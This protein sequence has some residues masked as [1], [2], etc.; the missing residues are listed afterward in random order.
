MDLPSEQS[1][2]SEP[3]RIK[4]PNKNN[5]DAVRL[6]FSICVFIIHYI[7]L[8]NS[9]NL[10]YLKYIINSTVAVQ[11][12]FVISGFLIFRSF[13]STPSI[14]DYTLKRFRRIYPAYGA[15]ILICTIAGGIFSSAPKN[16]TLL[17]DLSKYFLSNFF[18]MNFLHPNIIGVFTSN[19]SSAVNGALW[20]IKTEVL[21]YIFVPFIV[22]AI[23][24]FG[25]L[26]T[27]ITIYT[28]SCLYFDFFSELS[29]RQG[30]GYCAELAKQ[31]P[32]QMSYFISGA[33]LYYYYPIFRK[34]IRFLFPAA[35][36]VYVITSS[37][38]IYFPGPCSLA[39]MVIAVS[40]GPYW[41]PVGRYGDF[42]YGIYIW[43]FPVIQT[44]LGLSGF[45]S[46]TYLCLPFCAAL[47]G[48][49]SFLSWHLLEKPWLN[50]SSHYVAATL[51]KIT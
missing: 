11:G 5:M 13:E 46:S 14:R 27:I 48:I 35:A 40:F 26:R 18:F 3:S 9:T 23:R 34:R 47:V 42:S 45:S 12:F 25:T 49:I 33:A 22:Y 50:R 39:L 43:H 1:L 10:Y 29:Q 8:S 38:E 7:D 17:V 41:G 37:F 4:I 30:Y 28:M 31:L 44:I 32:G 2:F 19:F 36:I 15:T 24:K 21:F 6:I 16:I 51:L 20:T